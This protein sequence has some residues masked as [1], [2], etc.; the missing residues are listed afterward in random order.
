M[1]LPNSEPETA[2]SVDSLRVKR[3]LEYLPSFK[4]TFYLRYP[5]FKFLLER[6]KRK[7]SRP[8]EAEKA[9]LPVDS[10]PLV[11]SQ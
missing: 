2:P 7:L 10:F 5:Q 3:G 11:V 1:F 8:I 9:T 4:T 6:S